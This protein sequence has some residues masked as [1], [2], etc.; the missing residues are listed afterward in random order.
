MFQS[1]SKR[2][3]GRGN[4]ARAQKSARSSRRL[5]VEGMERRLMLSATTPEATLPQL[6]I[7]SPLH[8]ELSFVTAPATIGGPSPQDGGLIELTADSLHG[9]S[10]AGILNAAPGSGIGTNGIDFDSSGVFV[11]AFDDNAFGAYANWNDSGSY[12]NASPP[13]LVFS[14]YDWGILTPKTASSPTHDQDIGS[15]YSEGGSIAISS[16]QA[17]L[18]QQPAAVAEK[19]SPAHEVETTVDSHGSV[20]GTPAVTNLVPGEWGRASVFEMV[21]G[22][23]STDDHGGLNFERAKSRGDKTR[24]DVALPLTL[25][26]EQESTPQANASPASAGQVQSDDQASA[27]DQTQATTQIN[28]AVVLNGA[29]SLSADPGIIANDQGKDSSSAVKPSQ[30]PDGPNLAADAYDG[31]SGG[32]ALAMDELGAIQK[33]PD[34]WGRSRVAAA[35]ML[36]LALERVAA[37]NSRE[38]NRQSSDEKT[39]PTGRPKP[40]RRQLRAG[41]QLDAR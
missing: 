31:R 41:L 14:N 2:R 4:T 29:G 32:V 16:V 11:T 24:S 37:F 17:E 20:R 3:G 36:V 15:N 1:Q 10:V 25:G 33:T 8:G 40:I 19:A 26:G 13:L 34:S 28:E 9:T 6:S 23:H 35:V 5:R 27:S 38:A 21:N 22:T 30:S 39:T 18:K 12:A 7:I